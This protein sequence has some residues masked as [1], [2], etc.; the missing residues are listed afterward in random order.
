[1]KTNR[2][3]KAEVHGAW[4]RKEGE[5]E[6]EREREKVL[7]ERIKTR[8]KSRCRPG[9]SKKEVGRVAKMAEPA[10]RK[11]HAKNEKSRKLE[12]LCKLKRNTRATKENGKEEGKIG[13]K[14][15]I[16]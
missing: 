10:D 5:R 8:Q 16:A 12:I 14:W 1:V 15:T 3:W 4:Q 9:K 13:A 7:K 11:C 6:R 2:K